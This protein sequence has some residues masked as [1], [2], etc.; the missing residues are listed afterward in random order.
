MSSELSSLGASF[1]YGQ[2][3]QVAKGQTTKAAEAAAGEEAGGP[4]A[5]AEE[6]AKV[7]DKADTAVA[8]LAR[9][10]GN[11][12]AVVEAMA[13]AELALKAAVTVRDKVVE[14]Y[15]EILRMPV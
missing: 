11:A 10:E 5:A 7:F 1:G 14:A 12:Q 2:A 4:K 3:A 6:F 15:Q 9:G 13:E 8:E